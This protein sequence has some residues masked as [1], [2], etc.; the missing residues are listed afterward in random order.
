MAITYSQILDITTI[1][2]D[3]SV[4]FNNP[5][6]TTTY[7][8]VIH[9]YNGNT[10]AE[11]VCLWKKPAAIAVG[12]LTAIFKKVMQPDEVQILEYASPGMMLD[13]LNDGIYGDTTTA[14]K[15]TI[16]MSGGTE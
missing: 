5:V 15:V 13:T 7:I 11:T 10:S 6:G 4:L 14:L 16:W 1:A 2:T 9:I 8:R 12:A 3:S